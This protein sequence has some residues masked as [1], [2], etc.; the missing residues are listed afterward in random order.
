MY[1]RHFPYFFPAT[2][3][4]KIRCKHIKPILASHSSHILYISMYLWTTSLIISYSNFEN[5]LSCAKF[6]SSIS[7]FS[8]LESFNEGKIWTSHSLFTLLIRRI[9]KLCPNFILFLFLIL[10]LSIFIFFFHLCKWRNITFINSSRN[11]NLYILSIMHFLQLI[12]TTFLQLPTFIPL[13]NSCLNF[14]E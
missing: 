6:S 7:C 11:I 10:P 2:F 5:R 4:F 9:F 14:P 3:N 1:R 12:P 8:S 13:C